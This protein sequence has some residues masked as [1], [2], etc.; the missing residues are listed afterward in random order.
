M[1][2][3]LDVSGMR[4]ESARL[5]SGEENDA[6]GLL[7][8]RRVPSCRGRGDMLTCGAI[9][10]A[11]RETAEG[12]RRLSQGRG[13]QRAGSEHGQ[14]GTDAHGRCKKVECGDLIRSTSAA[15]TQRPRPR[16]RG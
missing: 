1:R 16:R 14:R 15:C 10:G 5:F 3:W 13:V 11:C 7:F 4:V 2:L 9:R 12:E 8:E 6:V